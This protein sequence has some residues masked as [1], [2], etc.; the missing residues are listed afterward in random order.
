MTEKGESQSVVMASYNIGLS[1][2]CDIKKHK[3]QL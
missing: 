2:V 3:D 1:T